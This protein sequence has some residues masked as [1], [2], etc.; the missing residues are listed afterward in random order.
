MPPGDTSSGSALGSIDVQFGALDF[1]SEP[2]AAPSFG[3]ETQ[4]DASAT[5]AG[6][7][8]VQSLPPAA[9][10]YASQATDP[11]AEHAYVS[12]K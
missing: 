1:G 4:V 7:G 11:I 6:G 3:V 2:S 8:G 10:K 5:G 9:A 12:W